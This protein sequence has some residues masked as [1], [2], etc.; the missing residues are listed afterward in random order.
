MAHTM[1]HPNLSK[2][3]NANLEQSEKDGGVWLKDLKIGDTVFV[4]TQNSMY[5]IVKTSDGYTIEGHPKYCPKPTEARINGST[6]GGS[7]IKSGFLGGGMHL[8]FSTD[9]YPRITT[10]R[11]ESVVIISKTP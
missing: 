9:I 1:P 4:Q 11:I 8:E 10:S 6:W 5:R 3:I 7:M 2:D